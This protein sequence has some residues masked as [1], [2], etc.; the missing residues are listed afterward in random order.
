MFSF[1]PRPITADAIFKSMP[2]RAISLALSTLTI[3]G[4]EHVLCR[5]SDKKTRSTT[6]VSDP[7]KQTRRLK[8]NQTEQFIQ[9]AQ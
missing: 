9:P 8:S 6:S 3:G 7:V 2:S 1:K 5:H 4:D